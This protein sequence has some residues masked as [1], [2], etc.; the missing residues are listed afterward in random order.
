VIE[1]EPGRGLSAAELVQ[2]ITTIRERSVRALFVEPQYSSHLAR[3][4]SGETG[5]PVYTLDPAVTGPL[6]KDAYIEIMEKNLRTLQEA[7]R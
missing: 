7:L 1:R 2:T 3:T 6:S 4:I 5:L